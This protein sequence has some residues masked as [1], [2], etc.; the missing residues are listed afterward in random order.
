MNN[1]ARNRTLRFLARRVIDISYRHKLGHLGSCLTALPIIYDVYLTKRPGDK[2]ILSAGHS[3]LALY[4]VLEHF[5][6]IEDAEG[7][8]ICNGIHP[9]RGPGID[10]STGSLGQGIT[11]GVGF[12]ISRPERDVYVIS[13]DGELAE[14]ATWEALYYQARKNLRNLHIILNDNGY[15][16]LGPTYHTA[17]AKPFGVEIV[18]TRDTLP[19]FPWLAGLKAHYQTMNESQYTDLL[20]AYAD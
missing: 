13:T 18:N 17:L 11:V 2:V 20:A 5:N 4:V 15:S 19:D 10:V 8:L 1:Y 3:G 9:V 6:L 14:G 12:A 7:T 16:A